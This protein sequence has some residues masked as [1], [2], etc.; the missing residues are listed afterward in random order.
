MSKSFV[1]APA[2]REHRDRPGVA[3]GFRQNPHLGVWLESQGDCPAV[4][5]TSAQ[6]AVIEGLPRVSGHAWPESIIGHTLCGRLLFFADVIGED[7]NGY[8]IYG[9]FG[10]HPTVDAYHVAGRSR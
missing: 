1:F 10:V 2:A 4:Q 3:P 6:A 9:A 8:P 7:S 5:I